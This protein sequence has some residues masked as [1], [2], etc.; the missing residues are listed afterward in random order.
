MIPNVAKAS[1]QL[2]GD[3]VD[4]APAIDQSDNLTNQSADNLFS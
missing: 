3:D 2:L 4:I 1:K